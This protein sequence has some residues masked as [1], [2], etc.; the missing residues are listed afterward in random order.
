MKVLDATLQEALAREATSIAWCWLLEPKNGTPLGFTSFDLMFSIF[1]IYYKPFTGF[2]PTADSNSE[3]LQNN[4]SQDLAGLLTSEQISA[5]D[6]L[7]GKFDGAKITCFQ[8]N[9]TDLP[10]NLTDSP[11]KHLTLYE[12]YIKRFLLSDIGFKIELRDDDWKLEAKLGKVTSKFCDHDLG[13]PGCGVDLTPYT[14]TSYITAITSRYQFTLDG[15]FTIGQFNRGKITFITGNNAGVT[16]DVATNDSGNQVTL[17]Q[18][19]PY[20]INVGDQVTIVQGC[21]KTLYDCIVR[22]DRATNFDGEPHIPTTDQAI[23]TPSETA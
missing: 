13:Q 10:P 14:F 15:S 3:G 7:S 4:N 19:L 5:H 2:T 18:P 1:G 11:P 9:V 8:V 21:G 16:R 12:R 6:I 20:S 17:W 23:N 22:Y